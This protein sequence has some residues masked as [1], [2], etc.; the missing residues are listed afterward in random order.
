[1]KPTFAYFLSLFLMISKIVMAVQIM[2]AEWTRNSSILKNCIILPNSEL[3]SGSFFHLGRGRHEYT[4]R[5]PRKST[6][7]FCQ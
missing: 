7:M 2:T 1:M 5:I 3:P 6:K 4:N